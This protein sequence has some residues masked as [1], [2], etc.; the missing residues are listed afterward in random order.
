MKPQ[1]EAQIYE[2]MTQLKGDPLPYAQFERVF[3][4]YLADESVRCIVAREDENVLGFA[5]VHTRMLMHHASPVSELQ[6]LVVAESC[7]GRGIGSALLEA[8]KR[9]AVRRK[10][11][12]LELCC[13]L[14]N[15][16][17]QGFYERSGMSWTHRKYLWKPEK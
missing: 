7:R 4:A 13:N 1:D 15:T 5:S 16:A 12:Q 2:L 14:K 17:A 8:A 9:E 6:E 3:A 10:S 11:P